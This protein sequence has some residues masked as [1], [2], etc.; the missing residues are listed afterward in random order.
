M[1]YRVVAPPRAVVRISAESHDLRF[2]PLD[3]LPPD[4]DDST[5][6]AIRAALPSR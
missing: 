6:Q 3:A 5:W 4:T 2:W 1:R